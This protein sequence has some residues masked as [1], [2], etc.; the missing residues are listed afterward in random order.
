MSA[1]YV[2]FIYDTRSD[3]VHSVAAYDSALAESRTTREPQITLRVGSWLAQ[4]ASVLRGRQ[5]GWRALYSAL[6]ATPRYAT[7]DQSVYSVFD[8]AALATGNDAPRLSLR[9]C[10]EVIQIA[11][12]LADP[13]TITATLR[14]R[15]ERFMPWSTLSPSCERS[16]FMRSN[17]VSCRWRA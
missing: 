15:A 13:A 1:Q 5:A 2:G 8:Y 7:N 17:R 16:G 12:R 14:R 3:Y 9:Y 10:N 6:A 11:Q 4:A